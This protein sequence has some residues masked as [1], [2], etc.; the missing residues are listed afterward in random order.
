ML[1]NVYNWGEHEY[2]FFLNFWNCAFS[3]SIYLICIVVE[4]Q[5]QSDCKSLYNV[6]RPIY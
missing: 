4:N 2:V 3:V 5:N 1:L 6:Y